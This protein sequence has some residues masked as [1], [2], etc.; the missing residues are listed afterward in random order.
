MNK[1]RIILIF[2]FLLTGVLACFAAL[3]V[4]R[5]YDYYTYAPQTRDG[6]IRA[7]VVPLAAD[8]SGRVEAVYV[9][10]NQVVH[11]G[12]L[13][14]SIDKERLENALAQAEA[15]LDRAESER[16]AA[17]REY[18]RYKDLDSGSVSQLEQDR[19]MAEAEQAQARYELAAADCALARLNLE[20]S[21]VYS[22]VNGIVT[23]LTLRPGV[24]ATA[25]QAV[26]PL[27]DT[28]SFYVVGYFE[29][30]KLRQI[31]I[32]M[33]AHIRVMGEKRMIRGHVNGL[34]AGIT[35]REYQ[36]SAGTL[37][38]DVNPTFSWVRLAQ[39]VPIRISLDEVPEGL[40]LVAGRT[41]SVVLDDSQAVQ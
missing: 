9:R 40:A 23:N 35:D 11:Q 12:D 31:E 7:D 19:R 15:T 33:P 39:R 28:D 21:D 13:L 1:A 25:G 8:V 5:L 17:A 41:V 32:G 14:F 36:T 3:V 20:R 10:D 27:V 4:W 22:P 26:L 34:A 2:K 38:P 16:D 29:E 37:L 24:Y 18:K 6:K 30:T